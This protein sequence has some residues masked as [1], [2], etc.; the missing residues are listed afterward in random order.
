MYLIIFR[1]KRENEAPKPLIISES[2]LFYNPNNVHVYVRVQVSV[3][4]KLL[5]HTNHHIFI[6]KLSCP[7]SHNE[8]RNN[9][10]YSVKQLQSRESKLILWK[11]I[12]GKNL[13]LI[14][15]H[16]QFI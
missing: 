14:T 10:S 2:I 4:F 3:K 9:N 16:M 12:L 15:N 5:T 8:N 7:T 13:L 6:L 1:L 11:W